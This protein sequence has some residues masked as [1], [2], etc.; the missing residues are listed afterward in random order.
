[1]AVAAVVVVLVANT[2]RGSALIAIS[3]MPW[4]YS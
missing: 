4:R 2:N 1:M 3:G